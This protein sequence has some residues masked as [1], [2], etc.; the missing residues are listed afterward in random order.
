VWCAESWCYISEECSLYD[1]KIESTIFD[2]FVYSYN[3][4]GGDVNGSA[5]EAEASNEENQ[6]N[7][8]VEDGEGEAS[9]DDGEGAADDGEVVDETG[10]C[11]CLT[12][13]GIE[14][15]DGFFIVEYGGV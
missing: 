8:E 3:K 10:V 5:D 6:D 14:Y 15:T 11:E 7:N 4:C 9:N 1:D 13:H 2:G 12:D